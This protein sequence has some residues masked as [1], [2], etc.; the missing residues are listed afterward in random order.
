[1]LVS[2]V[3]VSIIIEEVMTFQAEIS[4]GSLFLVGERK[5]RELKKT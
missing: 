4:L 1:M 5:E 2:F 3:Y